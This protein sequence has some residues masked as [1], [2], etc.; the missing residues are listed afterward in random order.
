MFITTEKN[1]H[2]FKGR[3]NGALFLAPGLTNPDVSERTTGFFLFDSIN[4]NP[5]FYTFFVKFAYDL[6]RTRASCPA[7]TVED[8]V[9]HPLRQIACLELLKKQEYTRKL[10]VYLKIFS[11]Q[12]ST[13][14]DPSAPQFMK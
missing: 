8:R 9:V 3:V 12:G 7:L 11:I 2:L 5:K 14:Y 6:P 10:S 4:Q 13:I 1:N